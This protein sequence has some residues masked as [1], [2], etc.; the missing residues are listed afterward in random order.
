MKLLSQLFFLE[1]ETEEPG[2]SRYLLRINPQHEI[3]R[4]HFPGNPI[5]PGVCLILLVSELLERR[6]ARTLALKQIVNVKFLQVLSPTEQTQVEVLFR[7]IEQ[8]ETHYH[9]K[10]VVQHD[11]HRFAQLSMIYADTDDA[12]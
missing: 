12:R 2:S 6:L 8:T 7:S 11:D 9:L 1:E 4:A 10:A 3:Y 5:T